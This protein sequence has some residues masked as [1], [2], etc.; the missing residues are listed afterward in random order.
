VK[1]TKVM[2]FNFAD[3]CQKFVF[4]G[5]IIECVQTIK[6]LG[7]L[8][9]TTLNLDSAVEHLT[10]ASRHSLFAL[11]H[12][13]AEL[14]VMDVKLHRDLFNTLV[15]S[16]TSYAYEVWVDSKKIETIEIMY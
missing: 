1:K 14:R 15:R 7:I 6:Y 16:T 12:C 9:K 5:D 3:P 2:V 10:T 13:C 4:E 11:N 8:L